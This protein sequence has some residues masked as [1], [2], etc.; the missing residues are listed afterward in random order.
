MRKACWGHLHRRG[1][2]ELLM[3]ELRLS[4]SPGSRPQTLGLLGGEKGGGEGAEQPCRVAA[5]PSC[6]QFLGVSRSARPLTSSLE[7]TTATRW[8]GRP[9]VCRDAGVPQPSQMS[10]KGHLG[11]PGQFL[12]APLLPAPCPPYLTRFMSALPC[13][14]YRCPAAACGWA[15]GHSD[16]HT[17]S[18]GASHHGLGGGD[19]GRGGEPRN[20]DASQANPLEAGALGLP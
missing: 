7:P 4:L 1:V 8:L 14:A 12:F 20:G 16:E 19:R 2:R 5:A 10:P 3:R 9:S 6:P 17:G 15:P 18:S 11:P 13:P